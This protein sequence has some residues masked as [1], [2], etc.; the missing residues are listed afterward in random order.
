MDSSQIEKNAKA[1]F[2]SVRGEGNANRDK[3]SAKTISF[4]KLLKV[5]SVN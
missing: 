1:S 5:V 2:D 3:A 4:G